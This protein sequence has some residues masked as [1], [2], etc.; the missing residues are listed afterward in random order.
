MWSSLLVG[1]LDIHNISTALRGVNGDFAHKTH[2]PYFN[3][4]ISLNSGFRCGRKPGFL[5]LFRGKTG[6]FETSP[7]YPSSL[8]FNSEMQPMTK[9][10]GR[11]P[12][13]PPG[14][15]MTA[16]EIHAR[17]Q[18]AERRKL[19]RAQL[20]HQQEIIELRAKRLPLDI[21]L[22]VAEGATRE[23]ITDRQLAAAI[24]AA[25]YCHARLNAVAVKDVTPQSPEAAEREK[26]R[27][28][29]FD[30]LLRLARPEPMSAEEMAQH[31]DIIEERKERD[32]E[33]GGKP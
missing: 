20:V 29:M 1:R 31:G 11:P 23:Q 7:C 14:R 10:T 32:D 27:R 16:K 18:A 6:F 30:A 19:S 12:G 28:Q 5:P 22:D 25:P 24:A 9:P 8:P 2:H 33:N 4:L 21:I 15:P 3:A 26:L 13:R 17:V